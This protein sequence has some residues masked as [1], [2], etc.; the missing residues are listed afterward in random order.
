[1]KVAIGIGK[2]VL[3][4]LVLL[5]V[6]FS[7]PVLAWSE[8]G[9]ANRNNITFPYANLTNVKIPITLTTPT[10]FNSSD[11]FIRNGADDTRLAYALENETRAW[12]LNDWVSANT[13]QLLVYYNCSGTG[14]TSE[15]DYN[16]FMVNFSD[17]FDTDLSQWNIVKN[18]TPDGISEIVNNSHGDNILHIRSGSKSN[19]EYQ[20]METYT[21]VPLELQ[22][23]FDI[24]IFDGTAY[25]YLARYFGFGADESRESDSGMNFGT[26]E[27]SISMWFK[28]NDTSDWQMAL[29][30]VGGGSGWEFGASQTNGYMYWFSYDGIEKTGTINIVNDTWNF[31]IVQR[32]DDG[33]LHFYI[34]NAE[35]GNGTIDTKNYSDSNALRIGSAV[36]S[37]QMRSGS[38]IDDIRIFNDK[39]LNSTERDTLWNG[40]SGY[41]NTLGSQEDMW[42]KGNNVT[43]SGIVGLVMTAGVQTAYATGILDN[44]FY[45]NGSMSSAPYTLEVPNNYY[46]VNGH[47]FDNGFLLEQMVNGTYQQTAWVLGDLAGNAWNHYIVKI[48]KNITGDGYYYA[49]VKTTGDVIYYNGNTEFLLTMGE[50]FTDTGHRKAFFGANPVSINVWFDNLTIKYYAQEP[51]LSYSEESAPEAPITYYV[52]WTLTPAN[53]TTNF[54]VNTTA[55]YCFNT[56]TNYNESRYRMADTIAYLYDVNGTEI[57]QAGLGTPTFNNEHCFVTGNWNYRSTLDYDTIYQWRIASPHV[58]DYNESVFLNAS[59]YSSSTFV[60]TTESAPPTTTT[61]TIAPT[62]TTTIE[63]PTGEAIESTNLAIRGLLALMTIFII[64]SAFFLLKDSV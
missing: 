9:C 6:M 58:Y 33:K 29:S 2:W 25:T 15:Q 12:I 22:A 26:G 43:D 32:E 61:T 60:F 28:S 55:Q 11:M 34:N 38:M 45:F 64:F 36:S 8:S 5:A 51:L 40:S 41:A 23:D 19:Y 63:S 31:L 50:N 42:F 30:R 20:I 13:T 17:N 48:Y 47:G 7:S 44:G 57:D 46:A 10:D 49:H 16:T 21:D 27:F 52:N 3:V 14:G 18:G 59:S 35:D 56:T 53:E 24:G 54:S 39:S 1:M 4:C 62:T 37:Y